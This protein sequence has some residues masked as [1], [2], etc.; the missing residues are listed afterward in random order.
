LLRQAQKEYP[1]GQRLLALFPAALF[2]LG[3]VP[4][5]VYRLG[6][7]LDRRLRRPRLAL[8]PA[9]LLLSALALVAG[10]ALALW[11]IYV[12]FTRGRGTP[13]PVMATQR[14]VVRPPYDRTRNPMALGTIVAY[15]GLALLLH[16]FGALVLV[17]L[18]SGLLLIYIKRVEEQEMIARFG[19]A[20][21]AYRRQ[22]PFLLPH[23]PLWNVVV[24]PHV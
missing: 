3:L 6:A 4:H 13:L 2:F 15:A 12:Q 21:R 16:S 17:A 20:Y 5:T 7:A 19:D 24:S 22:T 23:P 10:V 8:G 18:V 9:S 1:A 11:S 14:L